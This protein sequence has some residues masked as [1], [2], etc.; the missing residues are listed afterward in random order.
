MAEA[1]ARRPRL[2]TA[3]HAEVCI[4]V[5]A[6]WL[7]VLW[8]RQG[9]VGHAHDGQDERGNTLNTGHGAAD[10][11]FP[12]PPPLPARRPSHA[13]VSAPS[14]IGRSYGQTLGERIDPQAISWRRASVFFGP[15]Q[16]RPW[17]CRGRQN[18]ASSLCCHQITLCCFG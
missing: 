18:L 2:S 4:R 5:C 1:E 3:A 8:T 15:G 12:S 13:H 6:W 11:C 10:L 17:I 16:R 9:A 14:V 7:D